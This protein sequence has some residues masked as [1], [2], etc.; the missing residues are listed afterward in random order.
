MGLKQRAAITLIVMLFILLMLQTVNFF[1]NNKENPEPIV[2][3]VEMSYEDIL[4]FDSSS[5]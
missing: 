3:N 4:E 1:Q 2:V 5:K